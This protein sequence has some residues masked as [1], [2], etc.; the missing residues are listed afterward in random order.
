MWRHQII[1]TCPHKHHPLL[2]A[3][4]AFGM[5]PDILGSRSSFR[6]LPWSSLENLVVVTLTTIRIFYPPAV[7]FIL[8][9]WDFSEND[10]LE[11]PVRKHCNPFHS[12]LSQWMDSALDWHF[13]VPGISYLGHFYG[14]LVV[15]CAREVRGFMIWS[16]RWSHLWSKSVPLLCAEYNALMRVWDVNLIFFFFFAVIISYCSLIYEKL[17]L[18][19]CVWSIYAGYMLKVAHVLNWLNSEYCDVQAGQHCRVQSA[20]QFSLSSLWN[21]DANSELVSSFSP[22]F[23]EWSLD[24]SLTCQP[25]SYWSHGI[26]SRQYYVRCGLLLLGV[27]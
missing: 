10:L 2:E 24:M 12:K 4:S 25:Q 21:I 20:L 13:Q 3:A 15:C 26:F 19:V 6:H 23:D 18:D 5:I 22:E 27:R 14:S 16:I 9:R 8:W 7:V 1:A 11:C 17:V